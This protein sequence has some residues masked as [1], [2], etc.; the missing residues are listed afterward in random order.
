[1]ALNLKVE[2]SG[3]EIL[4]LNFKKLDAA[5]TDLTPMF[6][7]D[8]LPEM[9]RIEFEN[10]TSENSTGKSGKWQELSDG[11]R[12]MREKKDFIATIERDSN[13]LYFSLTRESEHSVLVIE[14]DS[15]TFGTDLP[16]AK[17]QHFGNP[18]RNLPARPLIDLSDV[19]IK[20]LGKVMRKSL[21]GEVKRR[22][23]FIATEENYDQF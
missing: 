15:F 20:G 19:Q 21:L 11:Y 9:R 17:A 22:T 23:S 6:R 1:M 7:N 12:E 18:K 10:F 13:D 3:K 8:V 14:K 16:Y 4:S 5:A 2:V